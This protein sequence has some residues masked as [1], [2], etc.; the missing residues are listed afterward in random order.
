MTEEDDSTITFKL[1]KRRRKEEERKIYRKRSD[2]EIW[3][4]PKDAVIESHAN[5]ADNGWRYSD[6][7]M[8]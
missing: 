5:S 1:K 4:C 8:R 7:G 2:K 6:G 3:W